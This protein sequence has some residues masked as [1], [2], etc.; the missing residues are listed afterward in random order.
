MGDD[1]NKGNHATT[2]FMKWLRQ[3]FVMIIWAIFL[4][5]TA[6]FLPILF[7]EV[8]QPIGSPRISTLSTEPLYIQS[9]FNEG[10]E[11]NSEVIYYQ[12]SKITYE[13]QP[14][15]FSK[16]SLICKFPINWLLSIVDIRCNDSLR[17]DLPE[18]VEIFMPGSGF[19]EKNPY[20]TIPEEEPLFNKIFINSRDRDHIFV[21][22]VPT[23][24][25]VKTFP[26]KLYRREKIL[27][28]C[29]NPGYSGNYWWN[30]YDSSLEGVPRVD[31]STR[32]LARGWVEFAPNRKIMYDFYELV[33]SNRG[34]LDIRGFM[35]TVPINYY[36][37]VCEDNENINLIG[38][39]RQ[40]ISIDL[41]SGETRRMVIL[42]QFSEEKSEEKFS[43][44]WQPKEFNFTLAGCN[45]D[46]NDQIS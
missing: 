24:T 43:T 8:V 17:I 19:W 26:F 28:P 27:I 13:V 11:G 3:H 5:I 29:L 42:N 38:P 46:W 39:K 23:A 33:L 20:I 15:M 44:A 9:L 35:T 40:Y 36:T 7:N 41:K 22:V 37:E 10:E 18:S 12:I 31:C 16:N 14:P 21:K 25:I 45:G 1:S 32:P 34:N 6:F 30:K 2:L 4:V